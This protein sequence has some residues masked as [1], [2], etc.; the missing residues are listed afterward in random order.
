[1]V[2]CISTSFLLWLDNIPLYVISH[3]TYLLIYLMDISVY[4]VFDS[5]FSILLSIYLEVELLGNVVILCFT[6]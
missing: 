1:M 4:I 2:A 6:F 3:F 5:L